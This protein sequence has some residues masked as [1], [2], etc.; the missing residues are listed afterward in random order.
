MTPTLRSTSTLKRAAAV[1]LLM[2]ALAGLVTTVGC[3]CPPFCNVYVSNFLRWIL[4][5][6]PEIDAAIGGETSP[7]GQRMRM[8]ILLWLV[9]S[10]GDTTEAAPTVTVHYYPPASATNLW[11]SLAPKNPQG[12]APYVF[13]NVPMSPDGSTPTLRVSY[14]GPNSGTRKLVDTFVVTTPSG[15]TYS[16][17]LVDQ[18]QTSPLTRTFALPER[19]ASARS[20]A[21]VVNAD[22]Q[23]GL[24][25][26]WYYNPEVA[27]D[28]SS[29][30]SWMDLVGSKKSFVAIRFPGEGTTG[31]APGQTSFMGPLALRAGADNSPR[32]SLVS[33]VDGPPKE[34]LTT[35]MTLK[36]ERLE[37]A[38]SRLPSAAGEHWTA[39]GA[40]GAPA[41][42]PNGIQIGSGKWELFSRTPMDLGGV[43]RPG[44][45]LTAYA[46]WEGPTPP[47]F[48]QG[49]AQSAGVGGRIHTFA[50][51]DISCYG[52]I[53]LTAPGGS[54]PPLEL[55]G[56]GFARVPQPARVQLHHSVHAQQALSATFALSSSLGGTAWKLYFGSA[57]APDLNRPVSGAVALQGYTDVWVVGDVP[58]G[59][60]GTDV[61]TL[62]V[63]AATHPTAPVW[64]TDIAVIGD[65]QPANVDEHQWLPVASH[66]PGA[67]QSAWRTDL[68]L[69]NPGTYAA[70]ATLRFHLPTGVLTRSQTVVPGQQLILADVVDGFAA[71]AGTTPAATGTAAL[72]VVA[73][74]PLKVSSRTYNLVGA[75]ATCHP[76]GTFGQSYEAATTENALSTNQIGWLTQLSENTAYRTNITLANTGTVQ[77]AVTVD[78]YDGAGIKV[79]SYQVTLGPGEY[80]QE[81]RPFF[82]KAGQSN[83][84]R[85][86]ARV[87]VTSGGGVIAVASVVDNRTNDPTTLPA[88]RTASSRS[89][90]QVGSHAPGANQS[91]WRTDL[92]VLNTSTLPASVQVRFH[93]AGGV[94]SN[95]I[96]VAPGQQA[97]LVDVVDEIP[98][99]GSAGLE[100]QSDRPVF[101]S[102]RTYNQVAGGATCYPNG[103]F[104]QGYDAYLT[105]RTL[106][107]GAT[108]YLTQ[109]Q[110]NAAY[111]TNIALTNTG[112]TPAVVAVT[113]MSGAG[114]PLNTYLVNL[115]S[116]EYKQE[117][118]P[119][120]NKA[121]QSN[122]AAGYAVVVV[123]S[124]SGIVASASV[125]DNLTNDP[126]TMPAI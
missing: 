45:V 100:V 5:L 30:Q 106:G 1:T 64:T 78:L 115:N 88:L 2:V 85:A 80:K 111:R 70:S 27:L 46:C 39:M 24:S 123:T 36:P 54:L 61:V 22:R 75:A 53:P 7:C 33:Y 122:L 116:G 31:A 121:G 83:L 79:G 105:T 40:A 63:T 97:I 101:V 55:S 66:A 11:F 82:N 29:C 107:P 20:S 90:V 34:I 48:F 49:A 109:L 71:A 84:D 17:H 104:G 76:R 19:A 117:N 92:G 96:T 56:P 12:P 94:K 16:T 10:G 77:A 114:V 95:T 89:W 25:E 38:E 98:E 65:W 26:M 103:T 35:A 51:E 125:V 93:K 120:F 3:Y 42:C 47:F 14:Q 118:R 52:P 58:A 44:T 91:Q 21:D 57:N 86:Y 6:D 18:A 69:L 28:Q 37:F 110:E 112:T 72:E 99:S 59:V 108:A 13:E 124:G 43:A 8:L 87:L 32:V 119:F 41:V 74:R 9:L 23:W 126:T 73:T 102:S 113:L 4:G 62:N 60:R 67:N 15:A 68:G 81:N 50:N